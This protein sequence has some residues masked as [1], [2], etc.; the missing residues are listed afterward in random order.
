[1][2]IN[3]SS[4]TVSSYIWYRK[5]PTAGSSKS[6]TCT[7]S[8]SDGIIAGAVSLHNVDQTNTFRD[9]DTLNNSTGTGTGD[10]TLTTVAGD[11][12]FATLMCGNNA[13]NPTNLV[14]A[15]SQSESGAAGGWDL[16]CG[17][18][19]A[20]N[21]RGGASTLSASGTSTVVSY[22]WTNNNPFAFVGAAVQPQASAG[23]LF[24]RYYDLLRN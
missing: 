15:G 11:L 16:Q 23:P 13:A 10:M 12:I 17:A 22:T 2:A 8:N 14:P 24:K 3:N 18:G 4:G 21:R 20:C 7:T 19:G 9:S 1:V 6:I 5:A